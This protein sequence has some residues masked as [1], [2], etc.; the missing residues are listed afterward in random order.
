MLILDVRAERAVL[1]E[2]D[3]VL[4][5]HLVVRIAMHVAL[6][7]VE[8]L[9]GDRGC[10]EQNGDAI[11]AFTLNQWDRTSNE[12]EIETRLE[13]GPTPFVIRQA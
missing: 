5:R 3:R 10:L 8:L 1:D 2:A 11:H 12:Q 7:M 4:L 9:K 13:S 6:R